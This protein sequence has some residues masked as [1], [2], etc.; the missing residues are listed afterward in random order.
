MAFE[1]FVLFYS[2]TCVVINTG[3]EGNLK[4]HLSTLVK[5]KPINTLVDFANNADFKKAIHLERNTNDIKREIREFPEPGFHKFAD[6]PRLVPRDMTIVEWILSVN[7]GFSRS[8]TV[9]PSF[10]VIRL[11]F[12]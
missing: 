7:D 11:L 4:S 9:T 12:T 3:Y 1:V 8:T 2:L 6:D 5:P 10:P